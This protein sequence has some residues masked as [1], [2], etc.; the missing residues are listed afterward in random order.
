[1]SCS[2][3]SSLDGFLVFTYLC[4]TLEH[5]NNISETLTLESANVPFIII[6]TWR[7]YIVYCLFVRRILVT[8][9]SGVGSRRAMTFC[10]VVDLGVHHVFSPYGELWPRG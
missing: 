7:G 5:F 9:I 6:P 1:M 10:R 3:I 2:G 8:D 4:F